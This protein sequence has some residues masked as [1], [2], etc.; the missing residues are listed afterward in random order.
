MMLFIGQ[1]GQ[2]GRMTKMIVE[3]K[4]IVSGKVNKM[5]INIT[6]QQ[7]FDFM[8]GR[9]GLA[10]EAFPDLSLDERE[11]IISGIHPTEWEQLFGNED[12]KENK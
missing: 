4:S 1:I 8:N 3:R 12:E 11:F 5:D 9:S 10:Q 6:Q 7:L 2:N